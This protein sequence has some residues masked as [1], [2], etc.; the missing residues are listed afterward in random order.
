MASAQL[1]HADRLVEPAPDQAQAQAQEQEQ[2]SA[3]FAPRLDA[4]YFWEDGAIPFVYGSVALAASLRV[5]AQP[6]DTPLYFSA[7]EGGAEVMGDTVPSF[8][9]GVYAGAG[10]GLLALTPGEARLHHFKGYCEAV[11][12]TMAVTEVAKKTFGRHRPDYAIGDTDPDQRQSFFSG[13]SSITTATSVY[14]GLYFYEHLSPR[15][16]G[17]AA[18]LYKVLV[19]STLAGITVGM[20]ISRVEDNRH[21]PS[22][23]LTGAAVGS[24]LAAGFFAYHEARFRSDREGFYRGNRLPIV[25]LPDIQNRGLTLATRW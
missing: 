14:L 18:G 22:D 24:A 19:Y 16:Q 8:V 17:P 1:A 9:V 21:N 6:R 15:L 11:L 4:S 10:A 12:T 13:H 20:P 23:V 3:A 25:V 5:F 7:S 2:A